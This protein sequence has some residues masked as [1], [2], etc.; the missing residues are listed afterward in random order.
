MMMTVWVKSLVT[1]WCALWTNC[2]CELMWGALSRLF[3][4]NDNPAASVDG[5][6]MDK[7]ASHQDMDTLESKQVRYIDKSLESIQRTF[8]CCR[9][10]HLLKIPPTVPMQM[11]IFLFC[12]NVFVHCCCSNQNLWYK[13]ICDV[14]PK[15]CGILQRGD[16]SVV[17]WWRNLP[18]LYTAQTSSSRHYIH[19]SVSSMIA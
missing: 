9:F 15:L 8:F 4:K 18:I 5:E 7:P 17:W 14:S 10:C 13:P 12:C 6:T 2:L 11:K 1:W 19:I 3:V 16:V